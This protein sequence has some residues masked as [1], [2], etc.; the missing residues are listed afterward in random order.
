MSSTGIKA[1]ARLVPSFRVGPGGRRRVVALSVLLAAACV[2]LLFAADSSRA[3]NGA[4]LFEGVLG[5]S[6]QPTFVNPMAVAVDRRPGPTAGDVLVVDGAAQ[7]VSRFTPAGLPDPF[8][9]LGTHVIDGKKGVGGLACALEPASCDE[10]PQNTFAFGSASEVQVAID[11]SG[12]ATDGNI[13]VTQSSQVVSVFAADGH[14]LGQ[15]THYQALQNEAQ[16]VRITQAAS[17][18]YKLTFTGVCNGAT[19]EVP[20]ATSVPALQALLAAPAVCGSGNITVSGVGGNPTSRVRTLSFA[21]VLADTNVAQVTCDG[22]GLTAV[23]G[24]TAACVTSTPQEGGLQPTA[25]AKSC[26]VAVD[27]DGSVY[28]GD[29]NRSMVHKYTPA[30]GVPTTADNLSNFSSVASP[31]SVAAGAGPTLGSIFPGT[32]NGSVYKVDQVTGGLQ[33]VVSNAANGIVSVDPASGYVFAVSGSVASEYD[34]SGVLAATLEATLTAPSAVQG[35]AVGPTGD[36][37]VTRAGS[38][39]VA[40]YGPQVFPPV[41]NAFAASGVSATRATLNGAVNAQGT[42]IAECRFEYGLTTSYGSTMPCA[43][44]V[45]ADSA[46]HPVSASL[47]GLQPNGAVYHYRVYAENA[48]G[49]TF[50]TP[51]RTFETADKA[52]TEPA[53]DVT[54]TGA[55]LHGTAFPEGTEI[56]GC[57]FDY[58]PTDAYG[59][60]APCSP[61]ASSIEPDYQPHD[62]SAT[63]AGLAMTSTYHFRLVIETSDGTVVGQDRQ[64]KT[65]GSP[66]VDG[67]VVPLFDKTTASLQGTVN[68]NGLPTKYHFEW[69]LTTAYGNDAPTEFEPFIG[70]GTDPLRVSTKLTG[71]QEGTTYHYRLVATNTAGTTNGA[72][73]VMETLNSCG[74]LE[75]RCVEMVSPADK[76]PVG[77]VGK[78]QAFGLNL[79]L[80]A[81]PAG[82]A[83][84]YTILNGLPGAAAGDEVLYL[85]RRNDNG[86]EAKEISPPPVA[87]VALNNQGNLY[88]LTPAVSDDLSC[89]IDQSPSP[90][91]ADAPSQTIDAGGMNLFRHDNVTDEYTVITNVPALNADTAVP[92]GNGWAVVGMSPDCNRVVFRSPYRFQG[93]PGQ[94]TTRLY[95]WDHGTLRGLGAI[96]AP[97]GSESLAAVT[98]STNVNFDRAVSDDA[99]RTIF[100]AASLVGGDVGQQ[101]VFLREGGSTIDVSQSETGIA[102]NAGSLYQ[103]AS[104]DGSRVFFTARYGLASNGSSSPGLTSCA[105]D[106]AG[107]VAGNGSGCDLYEYDLAA[108]PNRLT[109]LTPHTGEPQGAGVLGVLAASEDGDYVYFAA[110]GQLVP[111]QGRTATEN[112]AAG[113]YNI[114][115]SRDTGVT[116]A[117]DFVGLLNASDRDALTAIGGVYSRATP[118]GRHLLFMSS[119]NTTGYESGGAKMV[120]RYSATDDETVCLSCR[121]DGEPSNASTGAVPLPASTMPTTLT[122]D[123]SRAF[124]YSYDSLVPGAIDDRRNLYAWVHGQVYLLQTLPAGESSAVPDDNTSFFAGASADGRDVYFVTSKSLVPQDVDG[125]RDVYNVRVAG[126]FDPPAAPEAPCD[127]LDGDGCQGAAAVERPLAVDTLGERPDDRAPG[128]R[129]TLSLGT[130]TAQQRRSLASSGRLIVSVSASAAGRVSATAT[131]RLNNRIVTVASAARRLNAAG[132]TKLALRLS[133]AARRQLSST[134]RLR[135]TLAARHSAVRGSKSLRLTVTKPRA[136]R[137]TAP[138]NDGA[139]TR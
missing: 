122:T 15:L 72:D 20:T 130:P 61:S 108:S 23:V 114:Y 28:V 75:D 94:G 21:G 37:Y 13:Y 51:D 59:S 67:E 103:T 74:F 65:I 69:G 70:A 55:K 96:P 52:I 80:R 123:G 121:P 29:A 58:G 89:S 44:G 7:T 9:A 54:A 47:S 50:S 91:T 129:P 63:I 27:S 97:G 98:P 64:F 81:A 36:V 32:A 90:L 120:Y 133:R 62:V 125:R 76:G 48:A 8:P 117:V 38:S 83:I 124:F 40:V 56:T 113:S 43:E 116:R 2:T 127:P 53:S 88:Q 18:S 30:T 14:Y 66:L 137:A 11:S 57:R 71:L 60:T 39:T 136:R 4:R 119:A 5:A 84:A 22:S 34:A 42:S 68:P 6:Q 82:G 16:Q 93:I 107:G 126:G 112:Q 139:I 46:D 49:G 26:G 100:T 12:G 95:E 73:Q 86:W 41:V 134:G 33:Y 1:C 128:A 77:T 99:S 132:S 92:Y 85:G 138:A 3:Q 104:A 109:D 10:T 111:G 45:P 101:A 24:Q 110:R 118:D 17:G 35:L 102:N 25:F 31:C 135:L 105:S 79:R 106:P 115:L 78:E 87:P 131:A 19:V